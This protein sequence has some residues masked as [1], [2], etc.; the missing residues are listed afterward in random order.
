MSCTIPSKYHESALRT[1]D[2]VIIALIRFYKAE[3]AQYCCHADKAQRDEV[4]TQFLSLLKP[5]KLKQ[6]C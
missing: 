1:I 6:V 2:Y 4:L 5:N 3:C